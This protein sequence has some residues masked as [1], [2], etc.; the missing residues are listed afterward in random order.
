MH[1]QIRSS[2]PLTVDSLGVGAQRVRCVRD[3]IGE[4]GGRRTFRDGGG[5]GRKRAWAREVG[6]GGHLVGVEGGDCL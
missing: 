4:M 1:G 5:G 2:L 3:R 6:M